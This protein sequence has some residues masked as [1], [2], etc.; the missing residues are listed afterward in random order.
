MDENSILDQLEELVERLGVQI[1]H[2]AVKQD[3][4]SVNVI[5][6]LCLLEGEY[7]LILNTK[8][9]IREKIGF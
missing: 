1:R 6:G 2:D 3:E 4:N 8:A 7:V 9:T 5:G